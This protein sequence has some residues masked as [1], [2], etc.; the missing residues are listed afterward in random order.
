MARRVENN[1]TQTVAIVGG[2]LG[3][4]LCALFFAKHGIKVHLFE[5]RSDIRTQKVVKG[6][7]INMALSRRG[8]DAL[9]YVNCEDMIVRNGIPMRARMLHDLKCHT[10]PV[11]YGT[12]PEHE[13]ISIDRRILNEL[14]LDEA[15]KYPQINIHF[16]HKFVHWNSEEKSAT[17]QTASGEHVDFKVDGLIGYDG[18][19]SGVRAAMMKLDSVDFSQEYIDTNYMEFCIPAK[20]NEYAMAVNYLHIWPRHEFMLIAL[21]NQDKSFTT[22]LFLPLPIFQKIT[23]TD[24]LL[25]FFQTHFPDAISFIGRENLIETYFS[26]QPLPLVSIKCSPHASVDGNILLMG[27][28]AHSMVPFYGQGMNSAFEDTLVLFEKL[29]ENNFQLSKSFIDYDK[30]RRENAHAIVDLSMYNHHEMRHLVTQ[31]SYYWRK[32]IDNFLYRIIPQW[33]IPLY[34]MVTFTR[35]PYK[36]CLELR[37]RQDNILKILR[38]IGYSIIGLY[39]LKQFAIYV[40]KPFAIQFIVRKILPKMVADQVV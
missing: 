31:R 27:D 12:R 9:A 39:A 3:G 8:R 30:N 2:G 5:L 1:S 11:P 17:F 34:T 4:T 37:K 40:I 33:W 21:P 28:A 26:S 29:K 20:N 22:T 13:V 35:I 23:T 7:S 16:Q 36:Q 32:K 24:E 10:T 15:S 14:L 25:T 38:L 18:C 6:R 19:H